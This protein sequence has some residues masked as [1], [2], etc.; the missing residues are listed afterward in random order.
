MWEIFK[1][2]IFKNYLTAQEPL[3]LGNTNGIYKRKWAIFQAGKC[4]ANHRYNL[5]EE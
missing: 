1:L 2:P 3:K 4:K 5:N